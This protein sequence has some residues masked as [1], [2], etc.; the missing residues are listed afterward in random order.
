MLGWAL[1][2]FRKYGDLIANAYN[3]DCGK[4][5]FETDLSG[6]FYG[7][8]DFGVVGIPIFV[9]DNIKELIA[10]FKVEVGKLNG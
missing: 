5:L 2:L 3:M 9:F 8:E 1:Y 6:T 4:I 10:F 7:T